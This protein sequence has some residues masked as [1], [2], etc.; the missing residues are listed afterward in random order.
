MNNGNNSNDFEN[1]DLINDVNNHLLYHKFIMINE[2]L[3]RRNKKKNPA[4]KS[5]T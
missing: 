5:V 3:D 2:V 1:I 4:M